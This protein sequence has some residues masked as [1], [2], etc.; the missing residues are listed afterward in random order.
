MNPQNMD[1]WFHKA[2][3]ILYDLHT[4]TK[5]LRPLSAVCSY[6]HRKFDTSASLNSLTRMCRFRLILSVTIVFAYM[7]ALYSIID[8]CICKSDTQP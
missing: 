7:Q 6:C 3:L 8:R 5:T 2:N 4:L 1:L